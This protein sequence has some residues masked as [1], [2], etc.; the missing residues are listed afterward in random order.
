[1][2]RPLPSRPSLSHLKKQAKTLLDE[3]RNTDPFS[4]QKLLQLH[5]QDFKIDQ[6][7]SI[8][9][10][11]AQLVIA[12]QYGF[13][14]WPKLK[15]HLESIDT[16]PSPQLKAALKDLRDGKICIL[17]DDE[18]RENEGDF[19]LA[20]EK[21]TPQSIN[22]ITKHGRG[23]LCLSMTPE[24]SNKLGLSLINPNRNNLSEP[25]FLVSID[26]VENITTGVS[27]QDRAQTIRAAVSEN[28]N[29][30]SVRSP[31]HVF[32]LRAHEGG[33]R[34]RPGHTEGS[35]ELMKLAGLKPSAV[36]CEILKDDGTMARWPDLIDIAKT[37]EI[38]MIKISELIS[39]K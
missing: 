37:H 3:I 29:A 31:G 22:F 9:L 20:A 18:G 11:D 2:F 14:S 30:F 16:A 28:A 15:Q 5:P 36:I 33:V 24:H 4:A 26:A 8:Q 1:M 35:I 38:Q 39:L 17:F 13:E 10:C 25:A 23:T 6:L 7:S 32:P 21:V 27:A 19:V 12:R 34:V